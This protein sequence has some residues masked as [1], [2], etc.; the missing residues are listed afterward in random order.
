MSNE[1]D[2]QKINEKLDRIIENLSSIKIDMVKE[3]GNVNMVLAAQHES[4]KDHIRRTEILE[5]KIA[6][7][8]KHDAMGTGV[9]KF[10]GLGGA[11]A[12]M[13]KLAMMMFKK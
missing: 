8:E 4:L 2:D 3:I 12:G 11:V 9:I 5:Q 10:I 7:L 6:P 1:N 13:A